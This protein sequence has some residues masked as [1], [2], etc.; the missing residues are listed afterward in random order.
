MVRIFEP[1]FLPGFTWSQP[2]VFIDW[3]D[4]CS[5]DHGTVL[6]VCSQCYY[7]NDHGCTCKEEICPLATL[8]GGWRLL[9]YVLYYTILYCN[10][11]LYTELY[12]TMLHCFLLHCSYT[13]LFCTTWHYCVVHYT[14]L[15][16]FVLCC[17]V[18]YCTTILYCIVG[19]TLYCIVFREFYHIFHESEWSIQGIQIQY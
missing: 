2:G 15:Y 19:N 16:C 13:V 9:I 18:L 1:G 11:L 4:R 7:W 12:C 17:I 10:V 6:H 8:Y 14:M 5:C 3:A